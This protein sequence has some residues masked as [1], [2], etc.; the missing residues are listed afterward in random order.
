MSEPIFQAELNTEQGDESQFDEE[1]LHARRRMYI[2]GAAAVGIVIVAIL[3]IPW[4]DYVKA[5][6][7]VAPQRWAR[8]RSEAPGVV[9]EV[10]HTIGDVMEEGEVIAVLDS[11][12]Q[13]DAVES[14]RLALP[15]ERQKLADLELRQREHAIQREGADSVAKSVGE[16]AVN[17]HAIDD[18]RLAA[19]DP[20]AD[21]ALKG[22]RDFATGVRAELS[23]NRSDPGKAVFNGEAL[24][25]EV[26]DAMARYSARSAAV[27]D[28][29]TNVGG[30]DAG[31]QFN[32]QLDDLRFAYSLADHSMEEILMKYQLVER[33]FLAAVALR[34][35]CAELEREAMELTHSF[36]ALSASARTILG[37]PAEQSERVRG[38]E[39]ARRLLASESERLE[40]ERAGVVS[41]IAAAELAVRSAERNQGKTV[42]HAPIRGKLAGEPLSRFDAVAAN[43]SVGVVEDMSSPVLKVKVEGTD[44]RRI[45]VGQAVELGGAVRGTVVWKTSLEGQTVRDQG[46]N[47]L[48]QLEGDN[49]GFAMG[50]KVTVAIE[51]GRRSVL[52]RWLEPTGEIAPTPR[53]AFVDDPTELRKQVGVPPESVA[54]VHG[55]LSSEPSDNSKGADGG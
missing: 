29:L 3:A 2:L 31:R 50:D 6:G 48:I 28:Q 46:W 49:A 36:R 10:K 55:Q 19:L 44:F 16:R 17:A 8:V 30:V 1:A 34:A 12:S 26:R 38:A 23:K 45:R 52:G 33:G 43:A 7:R 53:M 32:F 47:V 24:H 41:E 9:R 40:S 54:A 51:V 5:N 21:A 4:R 35:P 42:I 14:A 39:E 13:R 20:V 15:R 27:A 11:D 37:S 22:V 25:Q 18:S